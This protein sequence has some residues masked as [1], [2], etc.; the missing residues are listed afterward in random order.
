MCKI[1][2]D[3]RSRCVRSDHFRLISVILKVES[4]VVAQVSY[5]LVH[6]LK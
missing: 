2:S 3:K 1:N 4:G 5:G 6:L